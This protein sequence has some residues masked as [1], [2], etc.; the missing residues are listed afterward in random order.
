MYL[1]KMTF[2]CSDSCLFSYLDYNGHIKDIEIIYVKDT[3]RQ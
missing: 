2:S 1:Q 3:K